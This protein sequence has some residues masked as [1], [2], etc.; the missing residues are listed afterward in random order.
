MP[1]LAKVTDSLGPEAQRIM[2]Q[3]F[4]EKKSSLMIADLI[5]RE[6][7]ETANERT[8]GR[9]ASEWRAEQSRR[10]AAREQASALIS[11]MK[12][13]NLVASEM[14]QALATDALMM[15]PDG[16][17]LQD[18]IKVQRQN[19]IAEEI[20]LKRDALELRRA[21]H[22][23][24][25]ERFAIMRQREQRAIAAA[26]ELKEKANRGETLTVGDLNRIR[27]I[28]GLTPVKEAQN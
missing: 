3:A 1:R 23:L 16:F 19:L 24:E 13:H 27:D 7:G 22:D 28:Y 14:I 10:Q 20:R 9:R 17:A 6:T 25:A 11:A 21:E 5:K 18:P 15:N 4:R 2:V 26:D 12:E 8:I